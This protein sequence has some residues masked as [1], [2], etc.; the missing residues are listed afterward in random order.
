MKSN[1]K[2]FNQEI[3]D[4][5]TDDLWDLKISRSV[6]SNENNRKNRVRL[7]A[8][9]AAILFFTGLSVAYIANN[10]VQDPAISSSWILQQEQEMADFINSRDEDLSELATGLVF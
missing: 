9:A 1:Q 10:T 2:N 4:R 6:L 8:A 7:S 3:D 5:L